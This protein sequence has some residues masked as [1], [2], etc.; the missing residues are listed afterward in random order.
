MED[1]LNVTRKL[2]LQGY[3]ELLGG[4]E[5]M[6]IKDAVH[7]VNTENNHLTSFYGK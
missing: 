4:I 1:K 2:V 5:I 3:N 7:E 6:Q